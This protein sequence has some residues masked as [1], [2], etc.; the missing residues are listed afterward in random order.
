MGGAGHLG[1]PGGLT[2]T[3]CSVPKKHGWNLAAGQM[4]ILSTGGGWNV[5]FVGGSVMC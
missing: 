5:F 1:G 2:K 3:G 4:G